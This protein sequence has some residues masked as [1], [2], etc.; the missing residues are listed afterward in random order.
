[1]K[2]FQERSLVRR[3]I[4]AGE[5][6]DQVA[7][8]VRGVEGK[9]LDLL[10]QHQAGHHQHFTEVLDVDTLALEAL[11]VDTGVLQQLNAVFSIYVI[12]TQQQ[13]SKKAY[14]NDETPM[15]SRTGIRNLLQRELE[16]K[17]PTCAPFNKFAL[18]ISKCNAQ[19]DK[20]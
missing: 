3:Q 15:Y 14:I 2:N 10:V 17:L 19:L 20:L 8:V 11:E 1:M 12:P 16:I 6:L 9:P 4:S 5:G 18:L 7:E 13:I